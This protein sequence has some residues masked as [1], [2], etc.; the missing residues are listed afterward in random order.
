VRAPVLL[1]GDVIGENRAVFAN[2]LV[3]L[4][5][6]GTSEGETDESSVAPVISEWVAACFPQACPS[7][8]RI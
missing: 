5:N 2:T 4:A 6:E 8:E 3:K 1:E 7:S